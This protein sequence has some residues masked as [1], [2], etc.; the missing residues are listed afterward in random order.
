[1]RQYGLEMWITAPKET[2]VVQNSHNNILWL[3]SRDF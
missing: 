3:K 2:L 1:M